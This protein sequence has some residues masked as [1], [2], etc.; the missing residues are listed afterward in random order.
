MDAAG[1]ISAKLSVL[2][3]KAGDINQVVTTITKVADQTNLLSLNAAIEAEKAGEYGRGFA[4]VSSE[5]RRLADQTAV[6]TYD[7]EQMVGE[8]QSAVSAGVMGMDKFSEEVRRGLHDMHEIGAKLSEIISQVLT[9]V[10]RFET[11]NEG[12]QAQATGAEQIS[13]AL[14]QLTEATQQTV[15][16]LR[17]SSTAIDELNQVS[18]NL[19]GSIARFKLV[20]A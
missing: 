16:S 20:A 11:V 2:N 5:I 10:P 18:G 3:E 1:S 19:H 6:A 9:L 8:I 15:E 12:M 4:V 7:I 13:E 14:L 17:Q